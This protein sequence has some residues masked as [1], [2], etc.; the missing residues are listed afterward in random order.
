MKENKFE[1]K[2]LRE[3]IHEILFNFFDWELKCSKDNEFDVEF[4][5][6]RTDEILRLIQQQ[7]GSI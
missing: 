3:K 2:E 4:L 5:E 6:F 7:G 1:Y